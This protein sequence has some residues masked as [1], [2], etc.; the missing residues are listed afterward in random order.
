MLKKLY[1]RQNIEYEKVNI[2]AEMCDLI[3]DYNELAPNVRREK[4]NINNKT[5]DAKT[6][7]IIAEIH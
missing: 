3:N 7:K 1:D 2:R 5:L 6:I 4:V